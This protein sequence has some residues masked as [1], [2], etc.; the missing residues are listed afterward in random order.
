MKLKKNDLVK[1]LVGKDRGREAKIEV[2]K[3]RSGRVLLTGINAYKRHLKP[4]NGQ[5]GGIIDLNRPLLASKV[6]LLCPKCH[7]ITRIGWQVTQDGKK[8]FCRKCK[9]LI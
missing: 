6:A 4:R 1:V 7:K 9:E 2:V 5:K 8:R 3:P